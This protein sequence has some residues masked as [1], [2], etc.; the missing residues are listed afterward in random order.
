MIQLVSRRPALSIAIA[1]VLL[2]AALAIVLRVAPAPTTA[3]ASSHREAPLIA[4]DPTG[5][6]T[7]TYAFRDRTDQSKINVIA[8]WIPAED[9][10]AG[11]NY[12]T[13]STT[14]RYYIKIDN[15]G[16]GKPDMTYMFTFAHPG[17]DRFLGR[18]EQAYAMT[19]T[20]IATGK[21]IVRKG[22]MTPPDYVG[23][24]TNSPSGKGPCDDACYHAQVTKRVYH[25]QT[26]ETVFAGQREDAFYGDIGA[27]FDNLGI[28]VGTGITGGGKDFFGGY[29]VHAIALQLPISAI[30]RPGHPTVGVWASTDR[31]RISVG[32]HGLAVKQ[33]VQVSRL[34]NPLF[35]ELI[36]PTNFK[37]GFNA[38]TPDT[39]QKYVKYTQNPI[40]ANAINALYP[41]LLDAPEH[42]RADL[43]E[44]LL[45][46]TKGLNYTGPH[47]AD[48][49]RL[50]TSTPI[51]PVENR[52]GVIAGDKGGY[53]NGRRLNDDVI[54]IY[55]HD[56]VGATAK[57]YNIK[58]LLIG[59]GVDANDRVSLAE[60]PYEADPFSGFADVKGSNTLALPAG[61]VQPALGELPV[62]GALIPNGQTPGTGLPGLPVLLSSFAIP[63]VVPPLPTIPLTIPAG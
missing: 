6:N 59:D 2:A 8:N 16:D 4:E 20:N 14:A 9:T 23:S 60:F 52:L 24:R 3:S 38:T 54:D 63:G 39:D 5:D 13:F 7:D 42:N 53:P 44:L 57:P 43:T 58:S 45:T 61:G 12:F 35:N 28:R 46:G 56:V 40:L 30:T 49:L 1:L 19:R 62:L 17:F 10:A 32:K 34:A 55:E 29:A 48:L 41:G 21:K 51:S 36:I 25:L 50:N 26:G 22:M 33:W 18:T 37:D 47:K 15:T 27:A 31:Q 11:P